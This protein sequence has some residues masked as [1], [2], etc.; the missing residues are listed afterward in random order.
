MGKS[1]L[2]P[3]TAQKQHGW[4]NDIRDEQ[5][6]GAP[7]HVSSDALAQDNGNNTRRVRFTT[8]DPNDVPVRPSTSGGPASNPSARKDLEK[9]Q[10]RDDL[11]IN[12]LA[13]HSPEASLD[14]LPLPPSL[15]SSHRLPRSSSLNRAAAGRLPPD[16]MADQPTNL[17]MMIDEGQIG[18]AIGSP[19]QEPAGWHSQQSI[20]PYQA[21]Y[22]AHVT[23][24]DHLDTNPMEMA[25]GPTLKRKPSKW[26]RFFGGKKH[27]DQTPFYQVQPE[28]MS[29]TSQILSAAEVAS[30]A[31]PEK[32]DLK[33]SKSRG[34]SR[35]VSHKKTEA[36]PDM[37]RSNTAPLDF[38]SVSP[39]QRVPY[40]PL[41]KNSLGR[42]SKQNTSTASSHKQNLNDGLLLNI[43]LPKAE[44]E[45]YSVM[46]GSVLNT[47]AGSSSSSSLL[48]R[49][50]ATLERLKT[51]NDALAEQVD[52]CQDDLVTESSRAKSHGQEKALAEKEKSLRPRRG[53]SPHVG[54]SPSLSLFPGTTSTPL[55]TVQNHDTRPLRPSPL[56]RS[57]TS[58]AAISPRRP[59]FAVEEHDHLDKPVT[60]LSTSQSP[61]PQ[62]LRVPKLKV[63]GRDDSFP[64]H[65]VQKGPKP[66]EENHSVL[67]SP[68][69]EGEDESEPEPAED[70]ITVSAGTK[71]SVHEPVWEMVAR[72]TTASRG[73]HSVS[74]SVTSRSDTSGSKSSI[75]S[76][77]TTQH[78]DSSVVRKPVKT[79]SPTASDE[80]ATKSIA[81]KQ[82]QSSLRS[83]SNSGMIPISLYIDT[84]NEER[85]HVPPTGQVSIAR[86]VSVSR[87]QRQVIV[88]V[89][90]STSP[91]ALGSKTVNPNFPSPL[92]PKHIGSLVMEG[93]NEKVSHGKP[94]EKDELVVSGIKT[95]TPKL[96][97]V[98]EDEPRGRSVG[99]S[100]P[101]KPSVG[102]RVPSKPSS[103]ESGAKHLD[104]H[105]KSEMA[106]VER[107]PSH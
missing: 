17:G 104:L 26:K 61:V 101:D 107:I 100:T 81:H 45:R 85:K 53:T 42:F 70:H 55:L 36:K 14:N 77:V 76:S 90:T 48:A 41:I 89:K 106:L 88:P 20:H 8:A 1:G 32:G 56:Q 30:P 80:A 29:E 96:V 21:H 28:S 74:G 66:F 49:R 95:L 67:L 39:K 65:A 86:K 15:Q 40:I 71:S 35:T 58:P 69:S 27:T 68:D 103:S 91:T 24:P 64:R 46:F 22:G 75:S 44:F 37:K 23:S 19:T 3:K 72:P 43:D 31:S 102:K 11:Y 97:V 57:N 51:V 6:A 38:E 12:P 79:Q 60:P 18:M 10:T 50:Q 94:K 87:G 54:K 82:S 7:I 84:E 2:R 63:R 83:T 105:R 34:R 92:D 25:A 62:P 5:G 4:G 33:R 99:K 9:R 13:L 47:G 78:S 59:S 16:T 73:N 52:I 98:A 93:A